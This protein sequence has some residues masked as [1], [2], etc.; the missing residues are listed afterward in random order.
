MSKYIQSEPV[1]DSDCYLLG[2]QSHIL[3]D[4]SDEHAYTRNLFKKRKNKSLNDIMTT[5]SYWIPFIAKLRQINKYFIV[6]LIRM[7]IE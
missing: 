5:K 6:S 2:V 7:K 4:M 3:T 1:K